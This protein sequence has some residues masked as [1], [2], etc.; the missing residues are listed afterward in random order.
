MTRALVTGGT[1]FAGRYLVQQLAGDGVDV[2]VTS[3]AAHVDAPGASTVHAVDVRRADA[4]RGLVR[5]V[6][7]GI[8]AIR[9]EGRPSKRLRRD[10]ERMLRPGRG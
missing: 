9:G 5:D 2:H 6:A 8:K 7:P 4:V 3:H 1:G 10:L